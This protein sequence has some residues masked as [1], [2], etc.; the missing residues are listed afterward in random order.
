MFERRGHGHRIL[1]ALLSPALVAF[2]A[3][4]ALTVLPLSAQERGEIRTENFAAFESFEFKAGCERTSDDPYTLQITRQADGSLRT[5]VSIAFEDPGPGGC[6]DGLCVVPLGART[7]TVV[8]EE[9]VSRAF[10]AVTFGDLW[11]DWCAVAFIC[12]PHRFSWDGQVVHGHICLRPTVVEETRIDLLALLRRLRHGSEDCDGNGRP[13]AEDIASGRLDDADGDGIPDRCSSPTLFL[14][15]DCNDDGI[16]NL[17]DA[18]CVL[19]WLFDRAPQPGC[20][21]ALNM[22]GDEAVNV[23][24]PVFVLNFLFVGGPRLSAP[25]PECGPGTLP[26]DEQLGCANPPDCQ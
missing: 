11:E 3:T 7:L 5:E 10:R 12:R 9:S 15:G 2:G 19:N 8:E 6:P 26:A 21:A 18:A 1:R 25:Y 17:S 20:I 16:V 23:A 24:D 4:L 13:D 14:R 22:N